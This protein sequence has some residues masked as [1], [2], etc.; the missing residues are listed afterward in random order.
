MSARFLKWTAVAVL[1]VCNWAHLQLSVGTAARA[2]PDEECRSQAC[3]LLPREVIGT[4]TCDF[5][6]SVQVVKWC[7]AAP[8]KTCTVPNTQVNVF[9]D[10]VCV[11]NPNMTCSKGK[12][13][14]Q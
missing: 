14:C 7:F 5:S 9:C 13:K 3:N 4:C 8:T 2:F 1:V 11:G 10:G 6:G 12:L